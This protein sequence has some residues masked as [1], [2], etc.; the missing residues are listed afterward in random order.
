M[1]KKE[2]PVKQKNILIF[3]DH[4]NSS[5]GFF[6]GERSETKVGL[7]DAEIREELLGQFITDGRVDNDIV[8]RD[9]VDGCGDAV[10]VT[11][12]QGID[13]PQ[14]LGSI[15]AGGCW[16]GEDK[17]NGLFGVNNEDRADGEC[18]ALGI[19]VGSV[20]VVNHVI[21]VRDLSILVTD[22]GEF[23]VGSRDLINVLDPLAVGLNS[24]RRQTDEFDSTLG[25]L[26]LELSECTQLSGT[27]RCE[28]LRMGEEN[29]PVVANEFVELDF[30]IGGLSFEVR[31]YASKTERGSTFFSH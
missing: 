20:L 28:I 27:N 9:P 21:S 1:R 4:L 8:T 6:F 14:D 13:N 30:S 5:G 15:S 16:V 10:F 25:K 2:A 31:S 7:D 12:L 11:S 24:V 29:N 17:A 23:E 3:F 26:R 19:D 22:D 18:N